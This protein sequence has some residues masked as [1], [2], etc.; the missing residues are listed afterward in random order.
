LVLFTTCPVADPRTLLQWGRSHGVTELMIPRDIR[1]L[2]DLPVLGTGKI[3]YVALS[4]MAALVNGL[5][6]DA[7]EE[8]FAE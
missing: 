3:D 6:S 4:G 1:I 8:A 5:A 2:A 7:D